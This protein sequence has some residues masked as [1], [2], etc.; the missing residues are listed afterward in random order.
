MKLRFVATKKI[1][2]SRGLGVS[3]Y[4]DFRVA[5]GVA[6]ADGEAGTAPSESAEK[7]GVKYISNRGDWVELAGTARRQA[8]LRAAYHAY[9]VSAG[10]PPE[11]NGATALWR[12]SATIWWPRRFKWISPSMYAG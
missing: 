6:A 5:G 12:A 11:S 8:R 7:T 2:D 4:S 10:L 1:Q 9:R 3:L